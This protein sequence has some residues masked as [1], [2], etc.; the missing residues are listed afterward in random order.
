MW[1][2]ILSLLTP[3]ADPIDFLVD[4]V[5]GT[6]QVAFV[7]AGSHNA[8]SWKAATNAVYT[9]PVG[10]K[11]V[12]KQAYT[13]Q[14]ETDTARDARLFN[15]TD[16]AEVVRRNSIPYASSV[17]LWSGDLATASKFPEV[18]ASKQVRLEIWNLD[19]QKRSMM[20]VLLCGVEG[21]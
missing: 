20:W 3:N 21:A 15:V 10:K 13:D 8:N 9:V 6:G 5:A 2:S 14:N 12:V 18:A 4:D 1:D 17:F 19:S 7:Y 11:L 16:T